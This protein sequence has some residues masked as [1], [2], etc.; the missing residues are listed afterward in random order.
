MYASVNRVSIGPDNGL[1][2]IRRPAIILTNAW[3]P[4]IGP[5]RKQISGFQDK[6]IFFHSWKYIPKYR[7]GGGGGGG[8]GAWRKGDKQSTNNANRV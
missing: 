6:Y 1:L 7:G 5:F 3:S 2:P 8:G 4:S